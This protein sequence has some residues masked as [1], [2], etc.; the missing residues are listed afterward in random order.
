MFECAQ[1]NNNIYFEWNIFKNISI[2]NDFSKKS[3]KFK[4]FKHFLSVEK[5]LSIPKILNL[6]S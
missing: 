2:Q 3:L 1:M 4:N 6:F 5:K